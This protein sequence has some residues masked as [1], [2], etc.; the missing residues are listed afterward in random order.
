[1]RYAYGFI[2]IEDRMYRNWLS[3]LSQMVMAS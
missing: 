1:M 3:T 2:S